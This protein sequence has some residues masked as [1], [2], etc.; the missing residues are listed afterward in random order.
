MRNAK[1]NSRNA[2]TRNAKSH[3]NARPSLV[4]YLFRPQPHTEEPIDD[5]AL[6]GIKYV[7]PLQEGFSASSALLRNKCASPLQEGFSASSA[8]LRNKYASQLQ[9]IFIFQSGKA[10]SMFFKS[11]VH[12]LLTPLHHFL[13]T[14]LHHFLCS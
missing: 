10:G 7:S 12:F 6:L 9:V 14:L 13:L 8:L 1:E 2:G 4:K 11:L 3:R 5:S